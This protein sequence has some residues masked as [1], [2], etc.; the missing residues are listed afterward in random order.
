MTDVYVCLQAIEV[1]AIS[2]YQSISLSKLYLSISFIVNNTN[3]EAYLT[4]FQRDQFLEEKVK[5]QSFKLLSSTT[6]IPNV[7]LRHK[8]D[9]TKLSINDIFYKKVKN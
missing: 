4:A 3:C 5:Q 8:I 2:V 6:K 1:K 9:V 7:N